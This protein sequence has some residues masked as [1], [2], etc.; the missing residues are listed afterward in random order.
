MPKELS[1]RVEAIRINLWELLSY[2]N[3][4]GNSLENIIVVTASIEDSKVLTDALKQLQKSIFSLAEHVDDFS[5]NAMGEP[6]EI[7]RLYYVDKF[8]R[9]HLDRAQGLISD[10]RLFFVTSILSEWTKLALVLNELEK[11]KRLSYFRDDLYLTTKSLYADKE[12][13]ITSHIQGSKKNKKITGFES[14]IW[15]IDLHNS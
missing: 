14:Q 13:N 10:L 3:Q 6:D 4:F 1:W 5:S 9:S 12:G 15:Y 11:I 2:V 8:L 7:M